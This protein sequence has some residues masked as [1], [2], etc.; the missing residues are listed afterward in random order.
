MIIMYASRTGTRRNL[1]E[2]RKHGWRLL[3]SPTGCW[4]TEGFRYCL[5]NGAWTYH[6]RGEPF[7]GQAYWKFL[8]T[9]GHGADWAV[10]PDVVGDAEA[11][12]RMAGKWLPI[13]RRICPVFLALQDGTPE[14][15]V[16][17]FD[18][19][20]LF[21]GGSTKYKEQSA[22]GWGE[23]ARRRGLWFHVGRVNTA[24]RISICAE[25][26]AH[27]L[28]GT[29]ASRFAETIA[30]LSAASRQLALGVDDSRG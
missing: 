2:L 24:R 21:L 10:L 28:D 29:S 14:S 12:L 15:A 3:V 5:D 9:L 4:R 7:D 23:Y 8:C 17:G 16:D 25:A 19:D 20:G 1:A 13:A 6:Q 27:S 22:R 18:V 26:G 11:T 30:P